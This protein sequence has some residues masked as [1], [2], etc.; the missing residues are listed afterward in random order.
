VLRRVLEPRPVIRV[1]AEDEQR[2]G[3]TGELA[4]TFE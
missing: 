4:E 1:V 2:V 3:F